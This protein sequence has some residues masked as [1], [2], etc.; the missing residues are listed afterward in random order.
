[1]LE[2]T[3]NSISGKGLSRKRKLIFTVV[4]ILLFPF[5][6]TFGISGLLL[7]WFWDKWSKKVKIIVALVPTLLPLLFLIIYVFLFRP[8]LITGDAMLPHFKDR[9][10]VLA[11]I[12]SLR[13]EKPKFG[14]VIVFKAPPDPEKDLIKRVLGVTG[15]KVMVKDGNVYLND[16]LLDESKYLNPTVK[17]YTGNTFLREGETV[18]VPTDYYFVL[19]D[20]RSYSSDS[21]EWGF[22][23]TKSIIG[24]IN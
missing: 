17:T 21:R 8:F 5:L 15:D 13:F 19:G 6:P 10:Y 22:V 4:F 11:N 14:D 23:P 18:T 20:N 2:E 3:K 7:T 1:M 16:K 9:D 24:K 12:I